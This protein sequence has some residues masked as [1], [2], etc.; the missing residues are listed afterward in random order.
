MHR[1]G[2]A[3]R[4]GDRLKVNSRPLLLCSVLVALSFSLACAT[5]STAP[6]SPSIV[7]PPPVAAS[8]EPPP[9]PPV[10][11]SEVALTDTLP[12]D[13]VV[14]KGQL[15]NGLTYLVRHHPTPANRAEV[16]LVINAG[17]LQE[18]DDQR[19]FAHFLEHMAFNGTKRFHRQAM[20][21]YLESVG[22]RFGPDLNAHTGFDETVYELKLPTDRPEI[23]DRAFTIFEDWLGGGMTLDAAEIDKERGVIVEEWRLGRGGEGRLLDRQLPVLLANS[24]YAER[25]VIGD[26]ETLQHGSHEA[27][28]RFYRDWYRPDLATVLVVGDV[29]AAA[30]E[31]RVRERFSRLPSPTS[32]RP[33]IAFTVPAHA[34]TLFSIERDP[35]LSDTRVAV[36]YKHPAKPEGRYGDYRQMLLETVYDTM[37]NA[38]LAELAQ[39]KDPPFL[40]AAAASN[41]LVR[42]AS[43]YFQIAG[44]AAGGVPR[45]LEALLAEAERVSR[46]G[47]TESELERVRR[48]MFATYEGA[49][50]ER[51]TTES[52]GLAAEYTRH[53]LTGEPIPGIRLENDL[54]RHFLPTI[55]L[56]ELNQ[57]AKDWISDQSRVILVSGPEGTG[58]ELPGQDEL[59]AIYEKVRAQPLEPFVDQVLDEPLMAAQPVPGAVASE[60]VI[61]ELGVTEWRLA[62]GVRVVAK[63]TTFKAEEVLLTAFSPGGNSVVQDFDFNST[64]FATAMLGES[65]LGRFSAVELA[66]ALSGRR[67]GAQPYIAELEE[68]FNGGAA[69]ADLET[70]FQLIHLHFTAPR[71]DQEAVSTFLDKIKAFVAHRLESP[72]AVFMD[73]MTEA[74][75][76]NH[77]RRQPVTAEVIDEID[78][79]TAERIYRERFAD[80]S[81][82]TF[83]VVG[84]FELAQLKN[85]AEIYLGSLPATHRNESFADIGVEPPTG[86][87][88]FEIDR[89]I[90]PKSQVVL[91]WSGPAEWSRENVHALRTLEQALAIR[92]REALR[93][94]RGATYGVQ[95]DADIQARPRQRYDIEIGFGCSPENTDS[96]IENVFAELASLQKRGVPPAVVTKIQETQRRERET[97]LLENDFWLGALKRSY[98][99]GADPKGILDF[100]HLIEEVSSDQIKKTARRYLTKDRYVLGVLKPEAG[101]TPSV[102]P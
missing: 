16:W 74:L 57:L 53:V 88:R 65:G 87:V 32:P 28:R 62:N 22:L 100:D 7:A 33:R 52:R 79:A 24:R 71:A 59:L 1:S 4:Q 46:F 56:D 102:S 82:F 34:E 55:T 9:P 5:A 80:A 90:E 98:W 13:P 20:V 67:V 27:L 50:K 38:R 12:I 83:V 45:G 73:K 69:T 66:K 44:V 15:A 18:D 31:R 96:L 6:P 19:G 14:R 93:E 81:D 89:G 26:L 91:H 35:E 92:L 17:S 63:P 86:V 30:V 64:V 3:S 48:D 41:A 99:L 85:L 54:V 36:H 78:L 72:E 23:L 84:S 70:L 68:G 77:R 25:Q 76:Q 75:S 29:D 10:V 51:D 42:T 49:S 58:T 101:S 2:A 95:V 11:L 43:T 60:R 21:D 47:F 97:A 8:P 40:Y 61:A 39:E 94:D 37:M